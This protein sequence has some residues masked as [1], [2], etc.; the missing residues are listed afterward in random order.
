MAEGCLQFSLQA[1]SKETF[2]Y[3]LVYNFPSFSMDL[4][5]MVKVWFHPAHCSVLSVFTYRPQPPY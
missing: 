1:A 2:W 5:A 3:N 4:L